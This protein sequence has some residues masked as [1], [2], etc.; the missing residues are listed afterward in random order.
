MIM[1]HLK[2]NFCGSGQKEH[3]RRRRSMLLHPDLKQPL[4]EFDREEDLI[5]GGLNDGGGCFEAKT[6]QREVTE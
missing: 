6:N 4:C 2:R 3:K 1:M 5:V